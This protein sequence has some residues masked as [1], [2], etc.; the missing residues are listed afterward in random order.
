VDPTDFPENKDEV[1]EDLHR[2]GLRFIQRRGLFRFGMDS[3]LL[4]EFAKCKKGGK[5]LDLCTGTGIVPVLLTAR[6]AAGRVTGLEILPE[7]AELARR[8]V[9]INGLEGII[10]I[11][12]GDI[13]H[14]R[15]S[16]PGAAY[17]TVTA[18]P[19]YI[20]ARG[21]A[22][23]PDGAAAIAR[24]ELLCGLNDVAGAAAYALKPHGRFYMVHKPH[25]LADIIAELRLFKLEPKALRFVHPRAEKPPGLVL[26]EAVKNSNPGVAVLPPMIVYDENGAYTPEIGGI[27]RD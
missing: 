22:L 5:I 19:P 3:V 6:T 2:G 14:I 8:N 7:S 17:D 1:I 25:R 13:R 24:H 9:S 15:Q 16:L 4:A 18:N 10:D 12:T 21:G 26:V 20:K 11:I 27:Y 23:N